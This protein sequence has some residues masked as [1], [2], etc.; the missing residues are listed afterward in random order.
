MKKTNSTYGVY[1]SNENTAGRIGTG[2]KK[3]MMSLF[4]SIKNDPGY[5]CVSLI[6]WNVK[7]N[8]WYEIEKVLK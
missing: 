5:D 6:K 7:Y 8:C 4:E 2:T 3:E 1:I